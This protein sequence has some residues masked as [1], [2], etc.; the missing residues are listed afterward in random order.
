MKRFYTIAFLIIINLMVFGQTITFKFIDY[1]DQ[2]YLLTNPKIEDGL[3]WENIKWSLSTGYHLNW[4]P[5]TWWSY[6]IDYELYGLDP[7]GYHSTNVIIHILA[8]IL[9][10]YALFRMTERYWESLVVAVLFAIHPNMSNRWPGSPNAKM[11]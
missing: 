10:F 3:T 6:F 8:T 1:D 2:V 4:H 5:I 11:F 9:L 7:S